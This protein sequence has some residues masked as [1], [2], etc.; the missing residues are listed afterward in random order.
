MR[1][2]TRSPGPQTTPPAQIGLLTL[3]M[4]IFIHNDAV[5]TVTTRLSLVG[6]HATAYKPLQVSLSHT[7]TYHTSTGWL[8]WGS[9]G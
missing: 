5:F 6:L 3:F 7:N 8:G 1:T 9:F 2:A 4:D